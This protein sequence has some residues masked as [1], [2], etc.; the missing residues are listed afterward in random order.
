MFLVERIIK[1]KNCPNL[2]GVK[3]WD[4]FIQRQGS[5]QIPEIHPHSP[6]M[7]CFTHLPKLV[8]PVAIQVDKKVPGKKK[9]WGRIRFLA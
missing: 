3:F 6:S 7:I 5:P 4:G 2:H 8:H 1:G 9:Y